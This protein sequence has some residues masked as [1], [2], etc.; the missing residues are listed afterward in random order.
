MIEK[1]ELV[2][3]VNADRWDEIG[4]LFNFTPVY[5]T[6][7]Y[8]FLDWRCVP[9]E[10]MAI[11]QGKNP[12]DPITP[13]PEIKRQKRKIRHKNTDFRSSRHNSQ[14][15]S[16]PHAIIHE[17]PAKQGPKSKRQRLYDE[18]KGICYYCKRLIQFSNWTIEHKQPL[19]KG[20]KRNKDNEVGACRTC[21]NAKGNLTEAQYLSKIAIQELL[22]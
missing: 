11:L 21:N 22:K 13:Q 17:V 7:F 6:G 15:E 3:L 9:V 14:Y 8:K 18:Q 5:H 4:K 12:P 16:Q 10:M 20:G 19:S 1:Q 2:K